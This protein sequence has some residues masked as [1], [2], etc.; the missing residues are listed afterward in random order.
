[1]VDETKDFQD[2]LPPNLR[3]RY[4]DPSGKPARGFWGYMNEPIS[5]YEESFA[6]VLEGRN[7]VDLIRMRPA[8]IVVDILA[9]PGSVYD[10]LSSFPKGRG[11][12]VSLP[13]H[14]MQEMRSDVQEIYRAGNVKWLSE[15]ITHPGTWVNIEKWLD[16]KKAHLIMERGM[17]GLD[18][19]PVNKKLYGIL[20]N[21][22][23]ANLD[24]DGGTLLFETPRR[25]LV[26]K[27]GIDIDAWVK[28]LQEVVGVKYD[29][30]NPKSHSP[31]FE[32]GKVMITRTPSSPAILPSI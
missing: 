17:G 11:L 30:G 1:M 6:N 28:S 31:L 16:G 24:H 25:E 23:W 10:L 15:D 2:L 21:R 8:P 12:A 32:Y 7:I 19:L 13:D 18:W 20:I 26:L 3:K 27:K 4:L 22:A 29:P 9:P 14:Q 5:S